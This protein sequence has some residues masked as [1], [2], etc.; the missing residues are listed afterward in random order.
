MSR[1]FDAPRVILVIGVP[2][3]GKTTVARALAARFERSACIEGDLIQHELTVN[4]L[5][6][7]GG[8]PVDEQGRQLALRWRNCAALA[9]NFVG[10]GFTVVV[11]HAAST[12]DF[13]E[14]FQHQLRA[15]PL[16]LIVL[17]P[18]HEVTLERD[19][20]RHKQVAQ[21]FTWMDAQMRETL[22]DWGWWLD[23][24]ELDVEE[25]VGAI[26]AEGLTAGDL[27]G[28]GAPA[29]PAGRP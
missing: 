26:L 9:D 13:V 6:P 29:H 22:T 8:E 7:P 18:R 12:P 5:V 15:R 10:E 16:S 19:A 1:P 23:T 20:G 14:L 28:L 21:Y 25:T 4:G 17:A 2:G 24:S 11:E 3:A 27:D